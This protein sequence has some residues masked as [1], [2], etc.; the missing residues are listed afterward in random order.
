LQTRRCRR[1]QKNKNAKPQVSAIVDG[2]NIFSA[3]LAKN[4]E[5]LALREGAVGLYLG[6]TGAGA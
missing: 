3:E 5:M 6:W 2:D 1:P 4:V